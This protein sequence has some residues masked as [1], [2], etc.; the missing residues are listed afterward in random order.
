M[1]D[2]N[3]YEYRINLDERGTFYADVRNAAGKT[4]FEVRAEDEPLWLVEDGFMKHA[5]D[6]DGL[7]SYLVDMSV[8]PIASSLTL[9]G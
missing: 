5:R 6:V 7:H 4:I 8:L 1:I 2:P 9:E 3:A